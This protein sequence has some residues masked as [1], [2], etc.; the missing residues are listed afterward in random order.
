M[1]SVQNKW[2]TTHIRTYIHTAVHTPLFVFVHKSAR[3]FYGF[4]I[5]QKPLSSRGEVGAVS[6]QT[7]IYGFKFFSQKSRTSRDEVGAVSYIILLYTVFSFAKIA[8]IGMRLSYIILLR[9]VLVFTKIALAG[10]RLSYHSAV[11]TPLLYASFLQ[12]FTWATEASS[13]PAD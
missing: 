3:R 5:S 2:H 10:M 6:Y 9:T 4:K 12:S 8:D 1:Y 13:K 7:A 11:C